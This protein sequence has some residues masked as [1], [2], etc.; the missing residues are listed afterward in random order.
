MHIV[1]E[2]AGAFA[3]PLGPDTV[4]K[5]VGTKG[6]LALPCHLCSHVV[7]LDHTQLGMIFSV[8]FHTSSIMSRNENKHLGDI[9]DCNV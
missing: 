3:S 8:Q 5:K 6:R 7:Y 1:F 4:I 9:A 2:Y